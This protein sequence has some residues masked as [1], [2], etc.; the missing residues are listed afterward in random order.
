M[1]I[2]TFAYGPA[3]MFYVQ[4]L[5]NMLCVIPKIV[6]VLVQKMKILVMLVIPVLAIP[7]LHFVIM[8]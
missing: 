1:Y 2:Q 4:I 8:L 5:M 3:L 7:H 6:Q